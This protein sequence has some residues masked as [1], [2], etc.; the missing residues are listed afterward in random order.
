[1]IAQ[2][3]S[4]IQYVIKHGSHFVNAHFCGKPLARLCVYVPDPKIPPT[5]CVI[6][7]LM[8]IRCEEKKLW[9]SAN[10]Y[11]QPHVN[12]D[13]LSAVLAM[14]TTFSEAQAFLPAL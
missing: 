8:M 14:S 4:G 10:V 11:Y 1:V 3:A 5:D 7:R 13:Y 6:T 9:D 12:R 2:G